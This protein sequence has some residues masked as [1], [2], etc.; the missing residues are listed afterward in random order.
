[1]FHH[2]YEQLQG[3]FSF[4]KFCQK[5]GIRSDPPSPGWSKR[6]TFPIFFEGFPYVLVTGIFTV[7]E[8]CPGTTTIT[9]HVEKNPLPK[10][11]FVAIF[12]ATPHPLKSGQRDF[13]A[14]PDSRQP[15]RQQGPVSAWQHCC[16]TTAAYFNVL[17]MARHGQWRHFSGN[18]NFVGSHFH[19]HY[20][21]NSC[22]H[23]LATL[24]LGAATFLQTSRC[25][26]KGFKF[27]RPTILPTTP[28][29]L[30]LS[31]LRCSP[32]KIA[33]L[34]SVNAAGTLPDKLSTIGQGHAIQFRCGV[35]TLA[36]AKHPHFAFQHQSLFNDHK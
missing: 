11:K 2:I 12:L 9:S 15:W 20:L 31:T 27:G 4:G 25:N 35:Y 30:K 32:I 24:A 21:H 29:K 10:T 34:N 5:V 3:K 1:M 23:N 13:L 18:Y 26:R 28:L 36:I 16:I 8:N 14:T 33:C 22:P 19:R 6:P 17:K 7:H